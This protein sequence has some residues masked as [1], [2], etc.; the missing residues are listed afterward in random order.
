[1]RTSFNFSG[2]FDWKNRLTSLSAMERSAPSWDR[3]FF[4]L[5]LNKQVKTLKT[6]QLNT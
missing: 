1:V 4:S 6:K 2:F 3:R 5:K